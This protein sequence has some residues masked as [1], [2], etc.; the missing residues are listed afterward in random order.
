MITTTE[1]Q[2][3]G[4]APVRLLKVMTT[5]SSGGTEGQVLKLM[6]NLDRHQFDLWFACLNKSGDILKD[7]ERLNCPIAEYR[8]KSLYRPETFCRQLRFAADIRTSKIQ[9]V[10]SYNFYANMFALPAARIAGTPLVL[11]SIRD[12]GVY[13]SPAQK[14]MQKYVCRLADKILVNAESIRDWLLEEGYNEK[15]IV[16]IKNGIDLSLYKPTGAGEQFRSELGIPASAPIVVML[17]RLNYQ[18][19]VDEFIHAAALLRR[20]HPEAYFLIV[21][22]KVHYQ[23]GVFTEDGAYLQQLQKLVAELGVQDRVVF[24]GHRKNTAEVLLESTVSVLPSHS[25]GLSNSLLE[26]MAAGRAIVATDVGGTPELVKDGVNGLLVPVKS[27]A[28]LARAIASVLDNNVLA[29][30]LGGAGRAMACDSFSLQKMIADT[31]RLYLNE[32]LHTKRCVAA[33]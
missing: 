2:S 28:H 27:P 6:Q 9:I 19:G 33:I 13:L 14:V 29:E 15:K 3:L 8:I 22:A 4:G 25:E 12:R 31:Q 18:K 11:A 23:D 30:R 1:R 24:S 17:S 32:L 21:G 7:F 16:V 26:S 5:C 20:Q 10:H